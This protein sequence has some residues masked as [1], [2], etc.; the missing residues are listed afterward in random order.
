MSKN[1]SAEEKS[2]SSAIEG[3]EDDKTGP[4]YT[5][6][7]TR[8]IHGWKHG[9]GRS[10]YNYVLQQIQTTCRADPSASATLNVSCLLKLDNSDVQQD[11]RVLSNS[12]GNFTSL[13]AFV[14]QITQFMNQLSTTSYKQMSLETIRYVAVRGL[15]FA[16]EIF[17]LCSWL[18]S[19]CICVF[20][21][22]HRQNSDK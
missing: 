12:G 3:N 11:I 17:F 19:F 14:I 10:I 22:G 7:F 5:R 6:Y 20:C 16:E 1:A 4:F 2:S 21:D 15:F 8:R 13:N 18:C 9:V